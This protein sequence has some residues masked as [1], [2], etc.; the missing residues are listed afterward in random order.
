MISQ[1]FQSVDLLGHNALNT[2]TIYPRFQVCARW[3]VN[4]MQIIF[5]LPVTHI[6][7]IKVLRFMKVELFCHFTESFIADTNKWH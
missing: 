6:F 4:E 2:V 5:K 7:G 3:S 1:V